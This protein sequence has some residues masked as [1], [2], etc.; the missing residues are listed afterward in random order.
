MRYFILVLSLLLAGCPS[1][2][3]KSNPS[4][5][6]PSTSE[7]VINEDII[8]KVF[9]QLD[10]KALPE[11]SLEYRFTNTPFWGKYAGNYISESFED[12]YMSPTFSYSEH[13]SLN[14]LDVTFSNVA[15]DIFYP[16]D[17]N[18]DTQKQLERFDAI[19][20]NPQACTTHQCLHSFEKGYHFVD[21]QVVIFKYVYA[22]KKYTISLK[23]FSD[24]VN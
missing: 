13:I 4:T 19:K 21:E 10:G 12:H 16:E 20:Q 15:D 14:N 8:E 7:P 23:G 22:S 24:D 6:N 2:D 5:S 17:F 11:T 9:Q 1:D 18:F 3:K